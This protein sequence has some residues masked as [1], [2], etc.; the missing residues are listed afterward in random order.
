[1]PSDQPR[2]KSRPWRAA[3]A[4]C[5]LLF[6]YL[7]IAMPFPAPVLSRLL[8]SSRVPIFNKA[9][10][11]PAT[12]LLYSS[13]IHRAFTSTSTTFTATNNMSFDTTSFLAAAKNR[14]S[15][16]K[17]N[18]KAPVD[19]KKIEEIARSAI[20]D[21]P[22]S[23]N[24]QSARLVVLLKDDHDKFWNI[25]T[26][27]LKVHVPE[28]QW[29]HTGSRLDGFKAGYGTVG[30]SQNHAILSK[31]GL[32]ADVRTMVDPLLRSPGADQGTSE[33]V[34]AVRRQVSTVV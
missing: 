6:A 26:E 21:V 34:P 12:S 23:F 11:L 9:S 10:F 28:D 5:V 14:R 7:V 33:Q 27:I 22:S 2:V 20:K 3:I 15:I 31:I 18:K 25:V 24:S 8:L 16:Y 4:L 19:D 13:P 30:A 29:A 1:M 17:L 32:Q